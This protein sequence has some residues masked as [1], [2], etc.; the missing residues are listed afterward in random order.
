LARWMPPYE[1][2]KDHPV[3]NA[4]LVGL[5]LSLL[6]AFIPSRARL[7]DALAEAYP[8]GAVEYLRWHPI[9]TGMFNDD[10]WGGFLIRSLGPEHRVF[11]D[12]RADIY[13]YGGVLA[14]FGRIANLQGDPLRLLQKYGIKACLL[15]RDA[16]L[17]TMLAHSPDWQRVY[18]DKIST[19]FVRA[20]A[21]RQ[22]PVASSQLPV[23]LR[24]KR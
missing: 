5:S 19:I 10:L 24:P 13:E 23:K 1:P 8:V 3:A 6:A 9:P 20:A 17:V 22:L 4:V 16:P 12:G 18:E 7:N 14:D 21:G 2:Q 15:H 11:I